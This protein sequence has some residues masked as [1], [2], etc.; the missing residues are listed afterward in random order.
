MKLAK[1]LIFRTHIQES[2]IM[3]TREVVA[4]EC[5]PPAKDGKP[6][7]CQ[8]DKPASRKETLEAER[9]R[10]LE[11]VCEGLDSPTLY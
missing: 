1:L 3:S 6:T 2:I 9:Q 4:P 11:E 8:G 10:M 7:Y 5:E